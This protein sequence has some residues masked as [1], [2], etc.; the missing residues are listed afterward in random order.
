MGL[1]RSV[2]VLIAVLFAG[3][4]ETKEAPQASD[5][6]FLEFLGT[7]QGTGQ[8]NFDPLDLADLPRDGKPSAD[9]WQKKSS[10][11]KKKT[12]GKGSQR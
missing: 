9:P 12:E 7:F 8:K 5:L 3:T 2:F 6:E 4:G 1:R 10:E 11:E